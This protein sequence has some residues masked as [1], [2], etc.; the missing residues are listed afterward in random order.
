MGGQ[1]NCCRALRQLLLNCLL[2]LFGLQSNIVSLHAPLLPST[3]HI[4]DAER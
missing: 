2:S 1:V 4:I 3:F